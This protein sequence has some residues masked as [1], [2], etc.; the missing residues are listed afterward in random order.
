MSDSGNS[1]PS[2]LLNKL[3]NNSYK[4]NT[5]CRRIGLKRKSTG[6]LLHTNI[7][8]KNKTNITSETSKC[9]EFNEN[10][11]NIETEAKDKLIPKLNYNK[12][13]VPKNLLNK[14]QQIKELKAELKNSEQV[15]K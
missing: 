13:V 14:Q 5:P 4:V 8:K 12:D 3:S 7:L 9:L 11:T 1:V 10:T 2:P 15:R 6:T